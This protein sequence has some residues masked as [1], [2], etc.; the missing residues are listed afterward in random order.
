MMTF[1][2]YNKIDLDEIFV[3]LKDNKK[4]E[5]TKEPDRLVESFDDVDIKLV[6]EHYHPEDVNE[7]IYHFP[8]GNYFTTDKGIIYSKKTYC[9]SVKLKNR[10][11]AIEKFSVILE[12]KKKKLT[13]RQ[14]TYYVA[15]NAPDALSQDDFEEKFYIYRR[16]TEENYLKIYIKQIHVKH[17]KAL[18][19][20]VKSEESFFKKFNEISGEFETYKVYFTRMRKDAFLHMCYYKQDVPK[21]KNINGEEL[22]KGRPSRH[23]TLMGES[24]EEIDFESLEEVASNFGVNVRTIKRA[25]K[26]K[27]ENNTITIKKK[28]YILK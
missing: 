25:L 21:G 6:I 26:D 8:Y 27:K 22:K 24:G 11:K 16:R 9:N 14:L 2:D 4:N 20:E 28:K 19:Y 3:K 10:L 15:Q 13:P 18:G 1:T 5:I 17:L 7:K 12:E 23:I